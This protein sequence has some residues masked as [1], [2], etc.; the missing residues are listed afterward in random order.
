M[1]DL[2][3]IQTDVENETSP[4]EIDCFEFTRV[5]KKSPQPTYKVTYREYPLA[6]EHITAER[7][8]AYERVATLFDMWERG[9]DLPDIG[10][11][12]NLYGDPYW[13]YKEASLQFRTAGVL[14]RHGYEKQI[15]S[16]KY[17]DPNCLKQY[18]YSEESAILTLLLT[19]VRHTPEEAAYQHH[20][21]N[22]IIKELQEIHGI[23][24]TTAKELYE[25][26]VRDYSDLLDYT[27]N[28]QV[29]YEQD[30]V[31]EIKAKMAKNC[32]ILEET[33]FL[34]EYGT[35]HLAHNI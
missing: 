1:P 20:Y 4:I 16:P 26:G 25:L 11:W 12:S 31:A 23:G 7:L 34:E 13:Q 5:P 15:K 19:L 35:T 24:E 6:E 10:N 8:A 29:E 17:F 21:K 18:H 27:H 14:N 30:A 32:H 3:T 9:E 28:I 22:S 33:G 2:T